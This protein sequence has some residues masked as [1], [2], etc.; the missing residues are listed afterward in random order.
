LIRLARGGL[1]DAFFSE[2]AAI[3]ARG[4]TEAGIALDPVLL[5]D[6]LRLNRAVY[7]LPLQWADEVIEQTYPVAEAYQAV[8]RGEV[9]DLGRRPGAF[10]VERTGTVWMSWEDWCED[11]V[12]RYFMRKE[13]F[14]PFRPLTA[15]EPEPAAGGP[16]RD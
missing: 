2:S 1:L 9:P 14:Y 7:A 5:D 11:L 15:S 3:L 10:L 8:L 4:A 6:A 13:Y 16:G 12:R